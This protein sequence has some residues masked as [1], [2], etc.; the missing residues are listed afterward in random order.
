MKES[1]SLRWDEGNAEILEAIETFERRRYFARQLVP[2]GYERHFK[3]QARFSSVHTSTAIEGIQLDAR[4]AQLVMIHGSSGQ[5]DEQATKNCEDAYMLL[6]ELA[7]DR[8]LKI[9][10]G[11]IRV[12]NTIL[13]QGL[14]TAE[15]EEK[16]RYRTSG[17]IVQDSETREVRYVAPPPEW[18]PG[19]MDDLVERLPQWIADDP[20]VVAA[21]KVHFAMISIHP[22][23]DGNGRTARLLADLV[24]WLTGRAADGMISISPELLNR[25]QDYYDMLHSVQGEDFREQVDITDFVGFSIRMLNEAVNNLEKKI[26]LFCKRKESIEEACDGILDP[27][28]IIGFMYMADIEPLSTATYAKL[29][30]CSVPTARSDLKRLLHLGFIQKI[31]EGKHTRYGWS[32]DLQEAAA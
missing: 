8:F 9:D 26:L 18:I 22:F 10:Q 19:L 28:Q 1:L 11:L 6:E 25:R 21:A 2:P 14:T 3:D 15:A 16:G 13:Q 12:L 17:C 27:R 23:R 5:P 7:T 29:N 20:P 32:L 30:R 24:L 31:G 4:E